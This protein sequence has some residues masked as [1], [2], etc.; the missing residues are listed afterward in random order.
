MTT[1]VTGAAGFIG[2]YVARALAARGDA[3]VGL[4][5][6]NSYYAPELKRARAQALGGGGGFPLLEG[7]ICDPQTLAALW[8]EHRPTR[9]VHL[10]AQA[11]VRH[12]IAMPRPYVQSN[13]VG[14]VEILEACRQHSVEHLVYASTSS[15][16][17][18]NPEQP[19]R[20]S[21]RC[22]RPLSLYAATKAA[23]ELLAHSYA[24]LYRLPCT[25]LRFFTVYGPWGRPDM[26]PILF[27][28]AV[29]EGRPIRVFNHGNM[30]RDFTQ[31]EDIVDGVLGALGHPPT[32]NGDSTPLQVFNLG[33]GQPVELL[34]FIALIERSLG[35]EARREFCEMQSGDMHETSAD[36]SAAAAAF[37]YAPKRSIDQG[38]PELVEWCRGFDWP[39]T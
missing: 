20:E 30:R 6:F 21:A 23:N 11:G 25:A 8:R 1:L 36:I 22:D 38:V 2:A 19:F 14:F 32:A 28:R 39:Q 31:V 15:V 24:H 5:N 37:G 9:V 7:D 29:L 26:A 4:D 34:D 3:V 35:I 17:G 12:S 27:T 33:R 16:Y 18:L 10:A 13:L